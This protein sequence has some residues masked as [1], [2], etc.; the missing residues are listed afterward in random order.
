MRGLDGKL[1][2]LGKGEALRAGAAGSVRLGFVPAFQKFDFIPNPA[3]INAQAE[4]LLNLFGA[5][6]AAKE[7]FECTVQ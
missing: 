2:N 3:Q 7:S 5:R 4:K 1:R 6:A